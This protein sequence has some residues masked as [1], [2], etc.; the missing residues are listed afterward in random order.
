[1]VPQL[2][3]QLTTVCVYESLLTLPRLVWYFGTVTGRHLRTLTQ[4]FDEMVGFGAPS[5]V[6][7]SECHAIEVLVKRHTG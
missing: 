6:E 1:M 3:P 5:G 4:V 7:G 2:A